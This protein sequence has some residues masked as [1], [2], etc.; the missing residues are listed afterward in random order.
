M[1]SK[2]PR[3]SRRKNVLKFADADKTGG[4]CTARADAAIPATAGLL[5]TEC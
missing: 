3:D 5:V 4:V 2:S 1:R